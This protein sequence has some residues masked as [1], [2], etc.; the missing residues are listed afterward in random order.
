M[1][2][3]A[4][5]MKFRLLQM[6]LPLSA[7][8]LA[9]PG[10]QSKTE[11]VETTDEFGK[12]IRYERNKEDYAKHGRYERFDEHGVKAEEAYYHNDTLHGAYRLFYANGQL[13][14][15][16]HFEMGLHHGPYRKYFETGVLQI[17]QEFRNGAMQGKSIRYYPSGRVMEEVT[18]VN[19]EENGPFKEYYSNGMTKAE[20]SYAFVDDSAVE[21]GELREYDSTG[22][23]L[24]IADCDNGL[25]RTR[26]KKE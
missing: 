14:S 22:V 5:R 6:F 23:L 15:E 20:G 19:S 26:W 3:I 2:W 4:M 13:E 11:T 12:K 17:Q 1:T 10:C 7:L 9:L 8:L 16:Q 25:C 21:Q 18:I 24:R